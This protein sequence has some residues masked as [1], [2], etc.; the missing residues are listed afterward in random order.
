VRGQ[1]IVLNHGP[2]VG[3]AIE[4]RTVPVP[5]GVEAYGHQREP[6]RQRLRQKTMA[7]RPDESTRLV[8]SPGFLRGP[9]KENGENNG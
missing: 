3:D 9:A 5:R 2:A 8:I 1:E 7:A 4:A 6:V